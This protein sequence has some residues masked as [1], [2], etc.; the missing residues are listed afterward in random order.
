METNLTRRSFITGIA[1]LVGGHFAVAARQPLSQGVVHAIAELP[2][3]LPVTS[4]D[5]LWPLGAYSDVK[6]YCGTGPLPRNVATIPWI[7]CFIL[8]PGHGAAGTFSN[9]LVEVTVGENG[10]EVFTVDGT[11]IK[12]QP[13]P[14]R[15]NVEFVHPTVG[16]YSFCEAAGPDACATSV[17]VWSRNPDHTVL[18]TVA[19]CLPPTY[20]VCVLSQ[21]NWDYQKSREH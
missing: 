21:E 10:E 2:R 4:V 19:E 17:G 12:D 5:W 15:T 6:S 1:L 11:V 3:R 9:H 20:H 7:G 18:F 16:G 14:S 8:S 13:T